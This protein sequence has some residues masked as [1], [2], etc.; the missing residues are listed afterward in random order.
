MFDVN[1]LNSQVHSFSVC[2][3][4]LMQCLYVS[5]KW[6][7]PCKLPLNLSG[8]LLY[9]LKTERMELT[10]LVLACKILGFVILLKDTVTHKTDL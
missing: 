8:F 6:S 7:L 2:S 10:L 9:Y 4:L 5:A 3:T 1:T